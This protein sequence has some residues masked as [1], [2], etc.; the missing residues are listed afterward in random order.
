[1]TVTALVMAGGRGTRLALAEEKPLLKVGG[2]SVVDLVLAALRSAKKVDSIIVA[3]SPNTPRTAKYL[4]KSAVQVKMTP[5]KEY[6][7]DMDYAVK[8]LRLETVLAVAADLPLLTGEIVDDIVE[9]FFSCGKPALAIAV[10]QKTREKLGL[11]VGYAFNWQGES[12][13]YAGINML[14]GK[15]I[16]DAELE[17]AI[18]VL[19]KAEVAVNINTID[20][21]Q[22]AQEQFLK[23]TEHK[24]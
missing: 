3:V 24:S 12:V 7:S 5:G 2:K 17:Q 22:I 4:E 8:A 6:V 21:L 18:C 23:F 11:A 14:D 19:D 13:V 20:E 10:P 15:R 16:D 9:R 1:M